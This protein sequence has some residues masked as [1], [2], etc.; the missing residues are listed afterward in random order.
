MTEPVPFKTA[1]IVFSTEDT[2]YLLLNIL[3]HD[4]IHDFKKE[5]KFDYLF[6]K[7]NKRAN[8]NNNNQ[9][10][11]TLPENKITE[12]LEII[13]VELVFYIYSFLLSIKTYYLYKN[14]NIV[15]INIS[16]EN[17]SIIAIV[18]SK[19]PFEVKDESPQT[20]ELPETNEI[21]ME[22]LYSEF[23]FKEVE[24]TTTLEKT[25]KL[26]LTEFIKNNK[27]DTFSFDDFLSS[28]LSFVDN[29]SN[30]LN[31]TEE[32]VD[33][34]TTVIT[35]LNTN[36]KT[37]KPNKTTPILSTPGK[38]PVQGGTNKR[39][40]I[41]TNVTDF[42]KSF[43]E[44][45]QRISKYLCIN[46]EDKKTSN[47]FLKKQI[48]IL[49][50]NSYEQ[51]DN[52][53]IN[54]FYS[55]Y[56]TAEYYNKIAK[57]KILENNK[58]K[59]IINN[60]ASIKDSLYLK[61]YVFC[62]IS[63]ILD[64]MYQCNLNY[65]QNNNATNN[66][67]NNNSQTS[68][69]TNSQ[70]DET[71]KETESEDDSESDNEDSNVYPN[72]R[73]SQNPSFLQNREHQQHIDEIKNK[74]KLL[75][76]DSTIQNKRRV[77]ENEEKMSF[78]IQNQDNNLFYKGAYTLDNNKINISLNIKCL[79]QNNIN[80][81][82]IITYGD[83]TSITASNVLKKCLNHFL[84]KEFIKDDIIE[85]FKSTIK[86]KEPFFDM[87]HRV[88]A[89]KS[90][91]PEYQ[92]ILLKGVGDLFQEINAVCINGAY[93]IPRVHEDIYDYNSNEQPPRLFLANDRPSATRFIFMLTRA[94]SGINPNA[95][96]GYYPHNKMNALIATYDDKDLVSPIVGGKHKRKSTTKK[97]KSITRK[98]KPHKKKQKS[99]KISR[100]Y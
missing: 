70:N 78:S 31:K 86:E 57:I 13:K 56:D 26:F 2:K 83:K 61:Q 74:N 16:I 9:T 96:G 51:Y 68:S 90:S 50:T 63:S 95:M 82:E 94:I 59:F 98:R 10:G 23:I 27:T 53:L 36:P 45:I 81:Q 33:K 88:F 93:P 76:A 30:L 17:L 67:N 75:I 12:I 1:E 60:A 22:D 14:F 32:I 58:K 40:S 85:E 35:R 7:K 65:L 84:K 15:D 37:T 99:K 21:E 91:I 64:P 100:N 46:A 97:R 47:T 4:V 42:K 11:G 55:N 6:K 69:N 5:K 52:E 28:L 48:E 18:N 72:T 3:G 66:N 73:N 41:N 79:N 24:S 34:N 71:D 62:P 29:N 54:F 49:D 39:K 87:F 38:I 89:L 77:I 43:L 80:F 19:K 20:E 8:N 25:S 92:Y 44:Y